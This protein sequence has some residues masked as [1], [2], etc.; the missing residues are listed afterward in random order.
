M[1]AQDRSDT[2]PTILLPCAVTG[3]RLPYKRQWGAG[4]LSVMGISFTTYPIAGLHMQG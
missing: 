2:Y 3:I 4:I 1:C